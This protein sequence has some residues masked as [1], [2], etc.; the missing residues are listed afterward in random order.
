MKVSRGFEATSI[1]MVWNGWVNA[2]S[3]SSRF[4][5]SMRARFRSSDIAAHAVHSAVFWASLRLSGGA[6][7]ASSTAGARSL[8]SSVPVTTNNSRCSATRL[9]P[10]PK[11]S[12]TV[13]FRTSSGEIGR[14]KVAVSRTGPSALSSGDQPDSFRGSRQP[15]GG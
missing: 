10:W 7:S 9:L 8:S 14:A 15:D 3:R 6:A 11:L 5:S 12:C 2:A 13:M 1:T 4:A